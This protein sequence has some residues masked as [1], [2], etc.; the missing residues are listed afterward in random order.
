MPFRLCYWIILCCCCSAALAQDLST[1]KGVRKAQRYQRSDKSSQPIKNQP[2]PSP[3]EDKIVESWILNIGNHTEFYNSVQI[4]DSGDTRK[5]EFAPV[6]GAGLYMPLANYDLKFLPE[7]N[8]VLPRSAG[9]SRIIKN[10]FMFRADL[11]YDPLDWLRLRLGTSLLWLNQHGRGGSAKVNNGTG[12]STFYYPD[13]NRSSVNNTL[14]IGVEA[15]FDDWSVRLQT[16][17][18][19]VFVEERR[20][21][22]YTL[23][24]SYYWDR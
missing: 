13:E 7:F 5:I 6:L 9:S 3:T 10:L 21:V 17:T 22:S 19:F 4:N 1:P 20:Q 11:G 12:S 23:F 15:L 2:Q 18:Y 14:D 8:W 16:Y 24:L